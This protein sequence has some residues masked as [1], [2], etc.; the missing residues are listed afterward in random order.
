MT[1]WKP[2]KVAAQ[3][4]WHRANGNPDRA[5]LLERQLNAVRRCK[6]CGRTLSDPVSIERGIGSDCW[7]KEPK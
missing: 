2:A 3:A 6:R 7:E 4:A 1:R 5:D